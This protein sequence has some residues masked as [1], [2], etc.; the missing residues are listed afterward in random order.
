[1]KQRLLTIVFLNIFLLYGC[2]FIEQLG[3]REPQVKPYDGPTLISVPE[4][5]IPGVPDKVKYADFWIREAKNPD[6]IMMT[7]D[8][9]EA[10]NANNPLKDTYIIDV[11]GLPE[12]SS[13][14][15]VRHN[16]SSDARYI[17]KRDYYI[18]GDIPLE[19]KDRQRIVALMDTA[20]VPG[21]IHLK[22]GLML[23]REVGKIWPTTIPLMGRP[24]GNEFDMG[25][26]SALD[27]G[28]PVA[29]L[30]T[31][32][33]GRWSY[34]QHSLFTAWIPSDAASFGDIET[35]RMLTKRE[36]IIVATGH[37]VT[38]Y[39]SPGS[40]AA[41][42][43]IQMGSYL[44]LDAV[45]TD[46]CAVL[47]PGRGKNGELVTGKGFVRRDSNISFGFLPFTLRNVYRQSFLLYGRRYGWGGMFE[48]RDCSRY[49]L[50]VFRSFGFRLPRNSSR[51]AEASTAVMSL[52]NMSR[53]TKLETLKN[54]P[55]GISLVRLP[56]HIMLYLGMSDSV[57]YFIHDFWAWNEPVTEEQD[58]T[59]RAAR[60][61]V[62]DIML[63]EGSKRGSLLDR[64]TH[65]AIIGNYVIE[66]Q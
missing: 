55:G 49:A 61:D 26:V 25:M 46:Y 38:V 12:K 20:A 43:S 5:S 36:D 65:I 44:R 52:E 10:F 41:I 66:Q 35:A 29:L 45:G 23:R 62:T 60:I 33:D 28:E 40:G 51:L 9:I 7:L 27:M 39:G 58:I 17:L 47:V 30:H 54:S 53:E 11:L 6:D 16:I 32:R 34:V 13:G 3:I 57:P 59:Y 19:P 8:Q 64:I 37:R 56:G 24:N 2:S 50:D 48:E 21:T 22:Y 4:D 42:G 15:N 14:E 31:S 63:G 18:T 1:M